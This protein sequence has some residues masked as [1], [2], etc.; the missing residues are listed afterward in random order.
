MGGP[1][2]IFLTSDNS[3][4]DPVFTAMQREVEDLV[5]P[6]GVHVAWVDPK[7]QAPDVYNRIAR[8]ALRGQCDLAAPLPAHVRLKKNDP[9]PLG[10]TQV[11]EGRVLPIAD[12][13]CDA[14]RKLVGDVLRASSAEEQQELFG[15][16][17]GRV[18][19]H[20]LYHILL[21][22]RAHGRSGLARPAQTQA[23]LLAVRTRFADREERLLAASDEANTAVIP[24]ES[25]R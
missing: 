10:Q 2:T 25:T 16:S 1:V 4:P 15:R 7:S 3:V 24:S 17:L 21:R 19:A 22:T 23:E 20:E 5:V 9:E 11:V 14:V 12:V 8:I 6:S 13:H 18:M